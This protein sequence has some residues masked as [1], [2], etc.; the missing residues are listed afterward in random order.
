MTG[1]FLYWD[2]DDRHPCHLR[3]LVEYDLLVGWWTAVSDSQMEEEK[4]TSNLIRY[5]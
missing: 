5:A 3:H 2:G 1:D 4:V